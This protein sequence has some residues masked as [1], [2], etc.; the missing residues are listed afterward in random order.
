MHY[1]M[2]S[3]I[4]L[5]SVLLPRSAGSRIKL[6]PVHESGKQQLQRFCNACKGIP[7]VFIF[8]F[9]PPP[10]IFTSFENQVATKLM[11]G[12]ELGITF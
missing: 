5:S 3:F 12:L 2:L 9:S 11:W 8:F 10:P 7:Q 6:A 4:H 1:I